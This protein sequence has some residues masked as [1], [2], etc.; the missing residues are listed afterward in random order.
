MKLIANNKSIYIH[1]SG[2]GSKLIFLIPG[3]PGLTYP[4]LTRLLPFFD[5]EIYSVIIYEPSGYQNSNDQHYQEINGYAKE[6]H[7]LL[8]HF[9][10]KE[11]CLVGHSFGAA[12][13]LEYLFQYNYSQKVV[14]SNGYLSGKQLQQNIL[15]TAATLPNDFQNRLNQFKS[16]GQMEDYQNLIN[17]EWLPQ[18]TVTTELSPQLMESINAY[19]TNPMG[20][21]FIGTDPFQMNGK[22]MKWD[23]E[24]DLASHKGEILFI[25]GQND[26]IR[27]ET[28]ISNAKL[29]QNG[30]SFID[31]NSSHLTPYENPKGFAEIV[32][33]FLAD[34]KS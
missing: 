25:S 11:T 28:T 20:P 13:L 30:H 3:G 5:E 33:N 6:I 10:Y 2:I 19:A 34:S 12:L 29:F 31:E 14:I 7:D 27:P 32:I 24:T 17:T 1:K 26:Y 9:D 8:D 4:Y 15:N 18:T 23:R 16:A 21:Y 22:I